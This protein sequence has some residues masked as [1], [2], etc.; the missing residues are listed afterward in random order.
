MPEEK[1]TVSLE[2][3]ETLIETESKY[4]V[5]LELLIDTSALTWNNDLSFDSQ[6]VRDLIK[7]LTPKAVSDRIAE[8][9]KKAKGIE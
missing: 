8:L 4:L 2:R 3:Y 1:V 5:L 6:T 9:R 7:S